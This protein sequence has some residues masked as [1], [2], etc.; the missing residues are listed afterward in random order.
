MLGVTGA[1]IVGAV[2]PE[3]KGN[4]PGSTQFFPVDICRPSDIGIQYSPY[5]VRIIR[6]RKNLA[7]HSK[8]RRILCIRH[9]NEFRQLGILKSVH[10][11]SGKYIDF[12]KRGSCAAWSIEAW[13]ASEGGDIAVSLRPELHAVKLR[14]ASVGMAN[15]EYPWDK[16]F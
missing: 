10:H 16:V 9:L 4:Y 11:A 6:C 12:A 14:I 15:L 13:I 1:V 7:F 8:Q 5:F 3:S 2:D